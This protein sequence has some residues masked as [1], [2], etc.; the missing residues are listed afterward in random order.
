MKLE[1][2]TILFVLLSC[3]QLFEDHGNYDYSEVNSISI[4]SIKESYSV[5]QFDTLTITPY[6]KFKQEEIK[7]SEF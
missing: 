4:D 7:K 5:V 1:L 2:Y 6:L 3:R